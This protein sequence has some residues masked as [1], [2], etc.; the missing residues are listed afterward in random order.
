MV[1]PMETLDPKAKALASAIL[2]QESGGN[3][4]AKGASGESGG[5]QFMP[6][7]WKAWAGKHLGDSNAQMSVE[8]Q[9]RVAYGQIKSWKDKGYNPAQIASLWNSG[10][11][12]WEGK[13][14]TNSKGVK[15]D[16]PSYVR[17]VSANYKQAARGLTTAPTAPVEP[18]GNRGLLGIGTGLLKGVGSSLRGAATLGEKILSGTLRTVLPKSAE[19]AIGL[20]QPQ[21]ATSAEKLVPKEMVTPHGLAEKAGFYGEQVGEFFIPGG[22][23]AKGVKGA[24]AAIGASKIAPKLMGAAKLGARSAIGG[25]TAAG[26]TAI[27]TGG[28][29]AASGA[30]GLIGAAFP[31]AGAALRPLGRAIAE[32]LPSRLMNAQIKPLAKEFRFGRDPGEALIREGIVGN[33]VEEIG[34]RASVRLDEIGSQI[35]S[36]LTSPLARG[37]VIDVAPA[38]SVIDAALQRAANSGEQAL[39][40]R[41]QG[42]KDGLTKQFIIGPAGRLEEGGT[43]LL[44]LSPEMA[45]KLKTEIGRATKWTG[46]AFDN[47]VNKVR[48]EIYGKLEEAIG[49]A[50]PSVRPLNERYSNMLS[51]VHAAEHRTDVLRRQNMVGLGDKSFGGAV[52]VGAIAGGAGGLQA[53]LAGIAGTALSNLVRSPAV[54]SRL[55]MALSKLAPAERTALLSASAVI[56]AAFIKAVAEGVRENGPDAPL[57]DLDDVL[58]KERI[59]M[60]EPKEPPMAPPTA[61][62]PTAM[63]VEPTRPPAKLRSASEFA[64]DDVALSRPGDENAPKPTPIKNIA[65]GL[66]QNIV[67]GSP[68]LS[69]IPNLSKK[70][71]V[72]QGEGWNMNLQKALAD[73]SKGDYAGISE[74]GLQS[75]MGAVGSLEAKGAGLTSKLLQKLEGRTGSVSKQFIEDLAKAPEL[76]KPDR[77]LAKRVLDQ[78]NPIIPW[79]K[80]KFKTTGNKEFDTFVK[81]VYKDFGLNQNEYLSQAQKI[82][83]DA[84]IVDVKLGGSYGK[85]L[86]KETSDLDLE[87]YYRGNI[88]PEKLAEQVRGK[89]HGEGGA[90]DVVPI[91]VNDTVDVPKFVEQVKSELLPLKTKTTDLKTFKERPNDNSRIGEVTRPR[92]ESV[93]L[94]T[95]LRGKVENYKENVYQSPIKTS[96]GEVHFRGGDSPNYFAHTRIEDVPG[97]TRRV[98]EVQSDLFQKGRLENEAINNDFGRPLF[99]KNGVDVTVTSQ[100]KKGDIVEG[101]GAK[102]EVVKRID[103]DY[104]L[105]KRL[106]GYANGREQEINILSGGD[107]THRARLEAA[108][109]SRAGQISKLEPYRDIWHE[110]IIREEVKQAAK[111]GKTTLQF[112]TGETAM[113]IEKLGQGDRHPWYRMDVPQDEALRLGT[114]APKLTED[115][116]K[117]GQ[118]IGRENESWI[119]T[120]VLGNGKFKAVPK[121]FHDMVMKD[122]SG[123]QGYA[124]PQKAAEIAGYKSPEHRL[125]VRAETFDISG[126]VDTENPIYK[127]YDKTVS[128]YLKNKYNAQVVTDKQGV[129]WVQLNVDPALAG[130]PVEAF[131]ILPPLRKKEEEKRPIL[132]L[133]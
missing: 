30:A 59:A 97:N 33:S 84:G 96:A 52:G 93:T 48:R 113:K 114:G 39:V 55:A 122:K 92:H 46:Q 3:Y 70:V 7:T 104:V 40:S 13:V 129:T 65:K 91:K 81:S 72:S 125:S 56:R 47:E 83:P 26:Q 121:D 57:P 32:K 50:V 29:Q 124:N 74:V 42:V 64:S 127:F 123:Y 101:S 105:G 111:D 12:E 116:L 78:H 51:A 41:L 19:Q 118:Q 60:E 67:G 130:K 35:G 1:N 107:K 22:A 6:G 9:N 25:A 108:N 21:D 126:K 34:K 88:D 89:I 103:E 87:V 79:E 28:D 82:A 109:K 8:N 10:T 120:D 131:G 106:D 27:Q 73:A 75:G 128:K 86:P 110:R 132:Q 90:F 98:I 61:P 62:P 36:V 71:G 117:V 43:K 14:G 77:D 45:S 53:L 18:Q 15:Y 133:R 85:G 5:Y 80:P 44:R 115:T 16:V 99:K 68:L 24:E 69:S 23:I 2:K 95:E 38:I 49:S 54:Q 94:P 66:F 102:F 100:L 17:N 4:N 112:P 119:I 11:P 63:A 31:V 20:R 58:Q 76:K 37:K